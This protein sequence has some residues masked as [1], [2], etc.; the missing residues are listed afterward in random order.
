MAQH[1]QAPVAPILR[2]PKR[3]GLDGFDP[4]TRVKLHHR[5]VQAFDVQE[6]LAQAEQEPANESSASGR[7]EA[8]STVPKIVRIDCNSSSNS[9]QFACQRHLFRRGAV[10]KFE[11]LGGDYDKGDGWI[12]FDGS[13]VFRRDKKIQKTI[14]YDRAREFDEAT[15]A[16]LERLGLSRLLPDLQTAQM[17]D[18]ATHVGPDIVLCFDD[19]KAVLIR[20][21]KRARRII[22]EKV[23]HG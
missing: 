7:V 10:A 16:S 23:Q 20:A 2:R 9:Q 21:D 5:G 8:V 3:L 11:V 17:D 13:F 14:P 22:G 12:Y 4:K 6:H 19:G 15:E 18:P 1:A